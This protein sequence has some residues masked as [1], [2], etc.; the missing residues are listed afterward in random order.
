MQDFQIHSL[1]SQNIYSPIF[2]DKFLL[3]GACIPSMNQ[4]LFEDFAK[5]WGNV[6][7]ICLEQFHYNQL[8][9][10]LAS[11][12]AV[13]NTRKVGFLT[14][15][16]SPHCI[17]IHFASKYLM[18]ELKQQIEYEHYVVGKDRKIHQ[19]SMETID[20]SKTLHK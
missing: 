15:D 7:S 8:M 13:G 19:I 16:G 3:I 10:K 11:V 12:L 2:K 14:M 17:Q 18:R 1:L 20:N 6:V 9:A 4:E 5:E